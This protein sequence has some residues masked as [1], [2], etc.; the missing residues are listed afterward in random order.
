MTN[1]YFNGS[2]K[3]TF[4]V[5]AW[6]LS[7]QLTITQWKLLGSCTHMDSLRKI[8][9]RE[10][11][12]L[13]KRRSLIQAHSLNHPKSCWFRHH[14]PMTHKSI[15]PNNEVCFANQLNQVITDKKFSH[16]SRVF[17]PIV[18][19]SL[20]LWTKMKQFRWSQSNLHLRLWNA[21]GW[22]H[23]L[24]L[25]TWFSTVHENFLSCLL[26]GKVHPAVT[27][28]HDLTQGEAVLDLFRMTWQQ[29]T[30][31]SCLWLFLKYGFTLTIKFAIYRF[32]SWCWCD[33]ITTFVLR[34]LHAPLLAKMYVDST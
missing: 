8:A 5:H 16:V 32:G 15:I 2:W 19:K 13:F 31:R 9:S 29:I 23:D 22:S 4:G 12:C 10:R 18:E 11:N 27:R 26:G 14:I 7:F 24:H 34:S 3:A 6:F 21:I 20:L 1:F 28:S 17:K 33:D 25:H 30:R